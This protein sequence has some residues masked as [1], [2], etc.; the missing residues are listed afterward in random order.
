[1]KCVRPW[2]C[3]GILVALASAC[4]N[5][6]PSGGPQGAGGTAVNLVQTGGAG[7]SSSV[8]AAGGYGGIYCFG[9]QP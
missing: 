5:Q 6:S 8:G 9:L 7:S 3:L 2:V 1:M 4:D